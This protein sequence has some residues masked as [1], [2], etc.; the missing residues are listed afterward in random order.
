MKGDS[1]L[2]SLDR[3]YAANESMPSKA[4]MA[5]IILNME[6]LKWNSTQGEISL[7]KL[8]VFKSL[9]I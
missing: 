6:P 2:S 4:E 7:L 9:F 8:N 5:K 3:S 1:F